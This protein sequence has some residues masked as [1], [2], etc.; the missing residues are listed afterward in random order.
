MPF[1]VHCKLTEPPL[2]ADAS[3]AVRVVPTSKVFSAEGYVTGA[4]YA[5]ETVEV[6]DVV[7]AATPNA[8]QT[9]DF[10]TFTAT[11]IA[12]EYGK[13]TCRAEVVFADENLVPN[14]DYDQIDFVVM[15]QKLTFTISGVGGSC[16][17]CANAN[18]TYV[19]EYNTVVANAW[20]E[21]LSTSSPDQRICY[22]PCIRFDLAANTSAS[23]IVSLAIKPT[24]VV[25]YAKTLAWDYNTWPIVLDAV[26][27][28]SCSSWPT[29]ISISAVV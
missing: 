7:H 20:G 23:G 24:F 3:L 5:I 18:R 6:Q 14:T 13:R 17:G 28:Q 26:T 21:R 22:S 15:P 4:G 29:S 1:G 27:T 12:T 2:M 19:L 9:S 8:G 25:K 16:A 10:I 11:G